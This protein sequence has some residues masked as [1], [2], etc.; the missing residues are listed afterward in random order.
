MRRYAHDQKWPLLKDGNWLA[1]GHFETE[2]IISRHHFLLLTTQT[3]QF[4]Q[5]DKLACA[6]R[7]RRAKTFISHK[8]CLTSVHQSPYRELIQ[9][10]LSEF[11]F[12]YESGCGE[13][14]GSMTVFIFSIW[15]R[16]LIPGDK[17]TYLLFRT[18]K[19]LINKCWTGFQQVL[20]RQERNMLSS[21]DMRESMQAS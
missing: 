18:L 4:K 3:N 21:W 8:N 5:L 16:G 19:T 1:L 10:I 9:S 7:L 11:C 12:L 14:S 15:S 17:H 2:R 6:V 13:K 20:A